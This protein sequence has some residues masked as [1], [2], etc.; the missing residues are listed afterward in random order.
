M[1]FHPAFILG[2]DFNAKHPSWHSSRANP[3][4]QCL[5]RHALGNDYILLGPLQPTHYPYSVHGRPDVLD[6][7]AVRSSASL[8]SIDTLAELISDHSP[9]LLVLGSSA[10]AVRRQSFSPPLTHWSAFSDS[11]KL[12]SFPL[13]PLL[14]SES[15]DLAIATFS[16]TLSSLHRGSTTRFRAP[17]ATYLPDLAP[18]LHSKRAA[19][20]RWQA[21]RRRADK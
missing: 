1:F 16:S 3:R 4:G 7:F 6:I 18:L 21:F 15:L 13:A 2:G 14:T 19:R 20:R 9:V 5:Y 8:V 10:F 11:L 12:C 17:A